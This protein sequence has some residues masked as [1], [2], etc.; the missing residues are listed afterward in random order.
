MSPLSF[1]AV[2]YTL[3]G[4]RHLIESGF[5]VYAVSI[6]GNTAIPFYATLNGVDD[7]S[8]KRKPLRTLLLCALFVKQYY[9]QP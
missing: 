8:C 3:S 9:R 6:F 4:L 2:A 7:C 5:K 1:M